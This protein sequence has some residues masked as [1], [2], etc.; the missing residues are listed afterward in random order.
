MVLLF[1]TWN[2]CL[3]AHLKISKIFWHEEENK[4]DIDTI[5]MWFRLIICKLHRMLEA[6]FSMGHMCQ[7]YRS[8]SSS[9]KPPLFYELHDL[10]YHS[11]L[12]VLLSC[13]RLLFCSVLYD[14]LVS[15]FRVPL[16]PPFTFLLRFIPC[17]SVS[18]LSYSFVSH[19]SVL[20]LFRSFP[21]NEC[22]ILQ[23][24]RPH[25]GRKCDFQHDCVAQW[26]VWCSVHSTR[27]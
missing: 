2:L 20:F 11:F 18:F 10:C 25:P 9:S 5:R 8:F 1:L 22:L 13:T 17:F 19:L 23:Y 14:L 24:L 27:K 3:A 7:V 15:R 26:R 6:F 12:C 21:F 16:E 4:N